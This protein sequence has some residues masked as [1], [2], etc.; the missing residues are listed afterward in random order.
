MYHNGNTPIQDPSALYNVRHG[1]V[2][3]VT[4][5]DRRLTQK[6]VSQLL[7]THRSDFV[8]HP[9]PE[10]SAP[11]QKYAPFHS[12]PFD[13]H[14][15]SATTYVD[16]GLDCRRKAVVP[17]ESTGTSDVFDAT[18]TYKDQFPWH[19]PQAQSPGKYRD[20]FRRSYN[21]GTVV[22]F[23]ASSSYAADFVPQPLPPRSSLRP[24]SARR[25]SHPFEGVSSYDA[26]Y[27]THPLPR[28]STSCRPR[29]GRL[30]PLR[31]EADTEHARQYTKKRLPR[32]MIYLEP[33][34]EGA[35]LCGTANSGSPSSSWG[36][37]AAQWGGA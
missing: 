34:L 15:T 23:D 37:R 8:E 14:S 1:D 13:G 20:Q 27:K 7:S 16:H 17:K 26:A 30:E 18:S 3:V 19:K 35:S 22:P 4:L 33:E 9:L 12:M 31:F 29:T 32:D 2:I 28:A 25:P 11:V 24:A 21:R 10:K 5:D 6:E 36:G